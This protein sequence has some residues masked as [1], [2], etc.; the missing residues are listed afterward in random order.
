MPENGDDSL[1][2]AGKS[3]QVDVRQG[4]AMA[5]N[6]WGSRVKRA[7]KKLKAAVVVRPGSSTKTL[8]KKG[9]EGRRVF[10]P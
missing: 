5:N 1:R 2:H 4:S 9:S 3:M 10:A 6:D 7:R 8:R